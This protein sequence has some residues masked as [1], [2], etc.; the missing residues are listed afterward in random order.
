LSGSDAQWLNEEVAKL[1]RGM[2]MNG[3]MDNFFDCVKSRKLPISDV[4]THHRTMTSCH[5]CNLAML[6][7]RKLKWDPAAEQFVGDERANALLSR[8]QRKGYEITT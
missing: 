5:L 4:F 2:P 7:K 6:L 3:H 8:P 1:Y